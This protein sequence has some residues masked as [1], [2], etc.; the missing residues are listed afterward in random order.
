MTFQL[1]I[2]TLLARGLV[3]V[4]TN[5]DFSAFLFSSYESSGV[6][7]N[8]L[9]GTKEGVWETEVPQQRG[10][11]AEPRWGSDSEAPEAGDTC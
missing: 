10:P 8:L 9:R 4:Y 6:A 11:G 5:F 1:K 7:R 2:G 3:K